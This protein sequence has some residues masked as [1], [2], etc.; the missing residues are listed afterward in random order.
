MSADDTDLQVGDLWSRAI[1]AFDRPSQRVRNFNKHS[2]AEMKRWHKKVAA[3]EGKAIRL[4]RRFD[5]ETDLRDHIFESD[6]VLKEKERA[7]DFRAF[8]DIAHLVNSLQLP[9]STM[10]I[11][12]EAPTDKTLMACFI[13]QVTVTEGRGNRLRPTNTKIDEGVPKN[14]TDTLFTFY[15]FDEAKKQLVPNEWPIVLTSLGAPSIWK[16]KAD[17]SHSAPVSYAKDV[18]MAAYCTKLVDDEPKDNYAPHQSGGGVNW[19]SFGNGPAAMWSQGAKS[20]DQY[21]ESCRRVLPDKT[22]AA[23]QSL[24]DFFDVVYRTYQMHK[25]SVASQPPDVLMPHPIM[26]DSPMLFVL[27]LIEVLNYP[28][29]SKDYVDAGNQQ[30]SRTPRVTPSDAYYRCKINL[31]KPDGITV[32]EPNQREGVYGKRLHQVR[33]HWRIYTDEFGNFKK[34]TWI[35]SHRRGDAKLGVVHKDYVLTAETEKKEQYA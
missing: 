30:K 21:K 19:Q 3:T 25:S 16:A 6:L 18:A 15:E 7:H 4:A 32:K 27:K 11:E 26:I 33:G 29:I 9:F 2:D 34:R 20:Q 23:S 31:P 13:E 28:W 24:D 5:V 17:S 12:W 14:S 22:L 10:W 1:W 35:K 8:S